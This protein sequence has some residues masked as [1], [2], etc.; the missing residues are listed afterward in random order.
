MTA[1][2]PTHG[3]AAD[4]VALTRALIAFDTVNPPGNERRC[5][6]FLEGLLAAAGFETD[7]V[8]MGDGRASLVARRGAPGPHGALAFTGH[9][10]VVPLGANPWTHAPF[11]GE[12]VDDRLYGR[13]S[14]DMKAGVAAFVAAAIAEAGRAGEGMQLVLI[15]TAGEETG[16]QGAESVVAAGAQGSAGALVVAEPTANMPYVG[17]KGALWLR[18]I[19]RGV[20][21][22]GSMPERGD[23]AVYRAARAVGRL[24]C[25]HFGACRHPVLGGPTLNVGTFHGG[26]NINS[27]PDRA[28]V[29]IDART[30]PGIDHAQLRRQIAEHMEEP[31]ELE[32]LVDLP[33]VWTEPQSPWAARTAA[34][35]AEVTGEPTEVRTAT[36]FSDASILVPALGDAPTLILGPGEPTLAHQTDEWCSVARI[37]QACTIYR[38]MIADWA[39]QGAARSPLASHQGA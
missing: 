31:M 1:P 24:S 25:F 17:H 32:T 6:E 36:Y 22:H 29:E 4:P 13:G 35:V 10:D 30:V 28:V 18:A 20:T 5:A 27:V 12:I 9:I 38:R 23:N 37:H 26:L 11:A 14:S 21:A 33:G 3:D 7:L 15:I 39:A 2:A 8:P 19:A 16:C 34:L